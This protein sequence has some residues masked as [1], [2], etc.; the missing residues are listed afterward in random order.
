MMTAEMLSPLRAYYL[1]KADLSILAVLLPVSCRED[2]CLSTRSAGSHRDFRG[3]RSKRQKMRKSSRK[4][5]R[6]KAGGRR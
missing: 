5:L 1:W 2:S 6:S 4:R 3:Q